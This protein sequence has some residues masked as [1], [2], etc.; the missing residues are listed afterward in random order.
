MCSSFINLS[1]PQ[2]RASSL[3]VG[4]ESLLFL[5]FLLLLLF[6]S[7]F[8]FCSY[9]WLCSREAITGGSC[10]KCKHVFIAT[11]TK[12][13]F[14][15][16]KSMLVATK[17]LTRQN[18]WLSRQTRDKHTFVHRERR[19]LSSQTHVCRD[20]HVFILVAAPA[21]DSLPTTQPHTREKHTQKRVFLATKVCLSRQV[22]WRQFF[23]SRQRTCF[24]ATM[25]V[26][27]RDK[28]VF[29]ATKRYLWQLPPTIGGGSVIRTDSRHNAVFIRRLIASSVIESWNKQCLHRTCFI[30]M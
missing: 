2:S 28:R 21:N 20:K 30:D 24:F 4:F 13:V 17:P 8:L 12:Y 29:V 22:L 5:L 18:T 7:F 16:D 27:C 10:Y 6:L 3:T 1:R 9:M 25:D 23:F 14:C 11:S 26:F 19:V 15:R